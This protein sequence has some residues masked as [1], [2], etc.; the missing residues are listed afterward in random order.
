MN[1]V[2]VTRRRRSPGGRDQYGSPKPSSTAIV[3]IP[4]CLVA[5]GDGT[6]V[7]E[8]PAR[9]GQVVE[10]VLY[11]PPGADLTVDDEIFHAGDWFD[12]AAP[13]RPWAG[14]RVGGVEVDLVR[15]TG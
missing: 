8:V 15:A 12:I 7:I 1:R 14:E 9:R 6:R 5:P 4:G 2:T 13:P 11:A 3:S 10:L